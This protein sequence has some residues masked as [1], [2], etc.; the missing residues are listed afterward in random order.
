[1]KV[2][3]EILEDKLGLF[4]SNYQYIFDSML[5]YGVYNKIGLSFIGVTLLMMAAFYYLY[6]NPYAKITHW[7]LA[8]IISAVIGSWMTYSLSRNGLAEY[9]LDSDQAVVSFTNNLILAYTG[10]NFVLALIFGFIASFAL[11]LG[12]KVQPHLPF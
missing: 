2:L 8:L 6:K 12:S 3:Y 10:I 9:I 4:D 11:R 1:M 7:F 5:E